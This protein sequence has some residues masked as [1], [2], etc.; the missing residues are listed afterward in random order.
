MR[1]EYKYQH[2]VPKVHLRRFT[3]EPEN[4]LVWTFDKPTANK[5]TR[6]I[7]KT[8]GEEFF[9]D[10]PEDDPEIEE[11]LTEVEGDV[12][13]PYSVLVET[14]R[15]DC[16]TPN[17]RRAFARFLALQDMRTRERR[18]STR[19]IGRQVQKELQERFGI[20]MKFDKDEIED[21]LREVHAD[22]ITDEEVNK[23]AEILLE[24][25]WILI[26]NKTDI[27]FWTSDHPTVRHNEVEHPPYVGEL[28][29]IVDGVKVYF[30]LSPELMLVIADPKYYSLELKHQHIIDEENAIFFNELQIRQSN[31]QLYSTSENFE[32]AG[33]ALERYPKLK[34]P[35][36]KRHDVM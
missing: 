5:F 31:R 13:D 10:P 20:E 9:Y 17:D 11:Y 19:D 28:G 14:E 24:K 16:L 3:T 18:Q 7:T 29:L 12:R 2:Y 33:R 8:G 30:P 35:L 25:Y 1:D 23:A 6:S 36:R 15:L 22:S 27:P 32:L 4:N 26:K 21:Q 34:D